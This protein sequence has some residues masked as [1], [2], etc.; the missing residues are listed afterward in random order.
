MTRC[1]AVESPAAAHVAHPPCPGG[2]C[3]PS[4]VLTTGPMGFRESVGSP[5]GVAIVNDCEGRRSFGSITL[6]Q[7]WETIDSIQGNPCLE[8]P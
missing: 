8:Y 1:S 7:T 3:R 2:G 5:C 4:S 6:L